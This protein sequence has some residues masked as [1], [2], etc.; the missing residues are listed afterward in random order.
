SVQRIIGSA[1]IHC[2]CDDLLLTAARTDRLVVNL[3]TSGCVVCGSPFCI[4]WIREGGASTCDVGSLSAQ[5]S[6]TKRSG[7][8]EFLESGFQHFNLP[9][10]SCVGDRL[11]VKE[12]GCQFNDGNISHL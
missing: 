2:F 6:S 5:G 4:D 9:E 7:D 11:N 3:V 1:E 10:E 12:C 8:G